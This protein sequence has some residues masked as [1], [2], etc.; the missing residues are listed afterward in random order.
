MH[1]AIAFGIFL[2]LSVCAVLSQEEY[3]EHKRSTYWLISRERYKNTIPS[4]VLKQYHKD[5]VSGA[6]PKIVIITQSMI[7]SLVKKPNQ[8]G[9]VYCLDMDVEEISSSE[10]NILLGWVENGQKILLWGGE[11]MWEYAPLFSNKVKI[12][13]KTGMDVKLANHPVN[14]DVSDITFK[15]KSN[16]YVYLHDCPPGTE[17]IAYVKDD[18]IAGKFPYGKGSVYFAGFGEYWDSGKDKDR[19]TLN[20][21]HWMLGLPVLGRAETLF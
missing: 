9:D 5:I 13:G 11:D 10:K 16:A 4:E 20:F 21:Y 17:V 18:V 1:K 6:K 12:S 7:K 3:I 2:I 15:G 14:T 19:W 8:G